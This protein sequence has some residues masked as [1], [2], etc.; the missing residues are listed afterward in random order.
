MTKRQQDILIEVSPGETRAAVVD[1]RG[2]L[3][4]MHVERLGES[5]ATGAI[6]LGRVIR[7]EKGIG[8]A[9]VDIG[10]ADP[11]FLGK[12]RALTEGKAALVQTIRPAGGGKGAAL[13]ATPVLTGRYLILDPMRP[14]LHVSR[15][16]DGDPAAMQERLTRL[17]PEGMGLS[18]R[19][20]AVRADDA[21]LEA[22]VARL[23]AAWRRIEEQA[24]TARPP[25]LLLAG[26]GMVETLLRD[27]TG[28]VIVDEPQSFSRIRG[29]VAR[30][31]PD[32]DGAIEL[33]RGDRPLF[34]EAGIEEQLEAALAPA[35]ALKDGAGLVIETTEALCAI[36]VNMGAAG[37]RLPSDAAILKTNLSA[38]EAVARQI[39]LRN[40]G[41]TVVVD[42]ISMRNKGHRKQVVDAM[43]RAMRDDTV[44][45][46]VLG[47]TAAGLV[48]ITR[49]R[50][51]TSLAERFV[52]PARRVPEPLPG[53]VGCAALRAVLRHGGAGAVTL[54][55]G[56]EVVAALR[57]PLAEALAETARRLGRDLQL[58][59]RPGRAGF[60][61]LSA[62][63][64]HG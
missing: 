55:A 17:L 44:T 5:A 52:R 60:E 56:P 50:L 24:A 45:C 57:G 1:G 21:A 34:E 7:V 63:R 31:M 51:G 49:Q 61:I 58:D 25:A 23:T 32:L 3:L 14:G 9:F 38:A 11:G 26:A 22:E 35:V 46:D 28:R 12:A 36:D 40:I 29:Q 15:R 42:F 30:E 13:S 59:A 20:P 16:L 53:A 39:M 33:Y 8:A 47:M 43:R 41:G 64:G 6:H 4:A 27:A 48:E 19:A 18:A 62:G 54:A 10:A 2:Q 37:G